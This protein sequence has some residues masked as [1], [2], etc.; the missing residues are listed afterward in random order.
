MAALAVTDQS[1]PGLP[2]DELVIGGGAPPPPPQPE[3]P[4]PPAPEPPPDE[5]DDGPVIGG[6]GDPPIRAGAPVQDSFTPADSRPSTQKPED[7]PYAAGAYDDYQVG[8][9]YFRPEDRPAGR[10]PVFY[11]FVV[12][13]LALGGVL[14]FLLF[15]L[16]G[17]GSGNEEEPTLIAVQMEAFIDAPASGDRIDVGQD[18]AVTVRVTSSE[19]IQRFDL[20]VGGIVVDQAFSADVAGENSYQAELTARFEAV[21]EYDLVVRAVS[22]SGTEAESDAVGIVARKSTDGTEPNELSGRVVA[23]ASLRTGP[24]GSFSQAGTLEPG[25]VVTVVGKTRNLEWLL[26]ERGGGLW[27][28]RNAIDLDD[29][30][31]L[32]LVSD[33]SPTPSPVTA[34]TDPSAT[35]SPSPS[36]SPD[37]DAPDFIA[38]NAVLVDGG[39]TLR[40]TISNVATNPFAGPIV[41]GVDGVPASPAEQVVDVSLPPNGTASIDFDLDPAITQQSSVNVTVDPDNAIEESNEDNNATNFV[42]APPAEGPNLSL[43]VEVN[44]EGDSMDVTITNNGDPIA[45]NNAVLEIVVGGTTVTLQIGG[46]LGLADGQSTTLAALQVPQGT[47]PILVRLLVDGSV[48]ASMLVANP[49]ATTPTATPTGGTPTEDPTETPTATA[50]G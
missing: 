41:V 30:L 15:A 36:P 21:G 6:S 28:R 11:L 29:S 12:L 43:V 14:V 19:A 5:A 4:G 46:G 16:L 48:A 24:G 44:A 20:L 26:L 18:L 31:D 2:E 8:P 7:D 25:D 32:V 3:P 23:V 9:A 50:T 37:A 47:D 1:Q 27:V 40:V 34:T 45:T 33:P 42:L 17:G 10:E 49:N 22:V 38:T 35:A 39:R 13:G